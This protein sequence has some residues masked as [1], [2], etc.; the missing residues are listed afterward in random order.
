MGGWVSEGAKPCILLSLD[1]YTLCRLGT[2][3]AGQTQLAGFMCPSYPLPGPNGL[4]PREHPLHCYNQQQQDNQRHAL[5]DT[6]AKFN[7]L[8]WH[9]V[10]A[11]G[12]NATWLRPQRVQQQAQPQAHVL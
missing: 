10:T 1:E 6:Q 3:P 12:G 4:F 8:A 2:E 9:P 11:S 7:L 5:L